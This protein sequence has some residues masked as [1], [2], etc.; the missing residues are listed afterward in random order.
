MKRQA[1]EKGGRSRA[2]VNTAALGTKYGLRTE[3]NGWLDVLVGRVYLACLDLYPD[4]AVRT[5]LAQMPPTSADLRLLAEA[6]T[7]QVALF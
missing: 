1:R 5:V 2:T 4:E 3:P 7:G 6:R